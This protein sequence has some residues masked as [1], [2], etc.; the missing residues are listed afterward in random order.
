MVIEHVAGESES[1]HTAVSVRRSTKKDIEETKALIEKKL[2]VS[3]MSV[4]D[5]LEILVK[6]YRETAL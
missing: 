4:S 3:K 2:G 5:A 6:H 1:A